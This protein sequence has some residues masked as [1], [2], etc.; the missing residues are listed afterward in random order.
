VLSDVPIIKLSARGEGDSGEHV[1]NPHKYPS[2]AHH[3][4]IRGTRSVTVGGFSVR[5]GPWRC[6]CLKIRS[7]QLRL[8]CL[9]KVDM[10]AEAC[11]G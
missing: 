9:F 5:E 4:C 11:V 6:G 2:S 7:R 8:L 3:V 1:L 10:R